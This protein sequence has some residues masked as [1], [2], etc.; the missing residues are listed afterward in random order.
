[1]LYNAATPQ[2]YLVE[3]E[4]DWRKEKLQ[5]IRTLIKSA[6]PEVEETIN[7]KMLGYKVGEDFLFHLNAQKGYVSLYVG[8]VSKVDPDGSILKNVK[9]GKGCIRFK[10]SVAVEETGVEEFLQR[11]ME[12]HRSG[13]DLGCD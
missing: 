2:D 9:L 11:F 13:V 6:A 5:F 7:Y 12:R 8:N 4:N 1:M 10:K 3:L